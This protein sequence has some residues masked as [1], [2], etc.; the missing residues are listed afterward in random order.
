ML[1]KINKVALSFGEPLKP[2]DPIKRII[3]HHTHN[4]NLDLIS[5]HKLHIEKFK[6]A[7]IGYNYLIEKDGR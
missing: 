7:G 3:I 5:T 4:P 6:W 1:K 2:L